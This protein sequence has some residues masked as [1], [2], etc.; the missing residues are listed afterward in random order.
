M[1]S[2]TF[3]G[4]WLEPEGWILDTQALKNIV[5]ITYQISI[6]GHNF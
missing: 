6:E 2:S 4:P 5:V 1:I 3:Y